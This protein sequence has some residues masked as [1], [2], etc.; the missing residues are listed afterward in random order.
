MRIV[1]LGCGRVGSTLARQLDTDGHEVA[2]ID[3]NQTQFARLGDDF[4]GLT[5]L[6]TGIDEDVLEQAGIEGADVFVAVTN[7]DNTAIMVSQIVREVFEVP[8]VITRIYD[9][10]REELFR[11]LG[12]DTISP[13]TTFAGMIA[14]RITGQMRS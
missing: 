6:G 8:H 5:V 1:I 11:G 3:R 12:L 13:T 10:G 4:G 14:D 7:G 2:V 9:P